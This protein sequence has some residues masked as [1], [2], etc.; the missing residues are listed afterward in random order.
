M[1]VGETSDKLLAGIRGRVGGTIGGEPDRRPRAS[2]GARDEKEHSLCIGHL[3][4]DLNSSWDLPGNTNKKKQK[5]MKS[6]AHRLHK[7]RIWL[8]YLRGG[9]VDTYRNL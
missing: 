7:L 8:P 2:P 3:Y 6:C 1:E 9:F 5:R 4:L